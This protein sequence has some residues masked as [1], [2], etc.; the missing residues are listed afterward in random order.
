MIVQFQLLGAPNVNCNGQPL[1]FPRRKALALLAYLALTG[2]PHTR[3]ALA[4]LVAGDAGAG[5]T[6]SLRNELALLGALLGPCLSIERH[7]IRLAP[8]APLEVDALAFAE[9]ARRALTSRDAAVAAEAVA[10]YRG[11]LLEG[12]SLRDAPGFEEWLL[13]EREHYYALLVETLALQLELACE[14]G[15]VETAIIAGRRL[16]RLEPWRESVHAQLMRLL[17]AA[18]RRGEALA[19]FYHCERALA[20]ELGVAPSAETVALYRQLR[21]EEHPAAFAAP[22]A[23]Q[24]QHATMLTAPR[25]QHLHQHLEAAFVASQRGEGGVAQRHLQAAMALAGGRQG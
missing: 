20:A 9:T 22:P 4:A 5:E 24:K 23:P 15:E 19:Q 2:R 21:A 1:T 13:L 10:R 17:A 6:R 25:L 7:A 8:G 11:D 12:F 14:R 16:L 3:E 18:G